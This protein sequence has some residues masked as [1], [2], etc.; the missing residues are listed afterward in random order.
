MAQSTAASAHVDPTPSGERILVVDDEAVI[1]RLL[2][3][4]LLREG[5]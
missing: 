1:L 4:V 2:T 3:D 5:Y